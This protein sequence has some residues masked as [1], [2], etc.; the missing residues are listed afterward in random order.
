MRDFRSFRQQ[1]HGLHEAQLLAPFP[2]GHAGFLLK[3]SLNRAFACA[4]LLANLTQ[5]PTVTR[6]LGECLRNPPGPRIQ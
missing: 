1:A 3:E 6:V 4:A 5:R 2:E